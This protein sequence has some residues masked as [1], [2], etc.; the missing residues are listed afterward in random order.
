M[1]CEP[2]L[3]HAFD[4]AYKQFVDL[5]GRRPVARRPSF[6]TLTLTILYLSPPCQ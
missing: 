5:V 1:G 3:F 6:L 2:D 4:V